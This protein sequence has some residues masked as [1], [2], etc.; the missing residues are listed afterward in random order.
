MLLNVDHL[1]H[2]IMSLNG[3]QAIEAIEDKEM[4]IASNYVMNK[5]LL[6]PFADAFCRRNCPTIKSELRRR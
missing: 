3:T 2:E 5:L 1:E 4:E 6:P